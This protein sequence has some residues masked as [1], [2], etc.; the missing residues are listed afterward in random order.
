[1]HLILLYGPWT[2]KHK[3]DHTDL[4][5]NITGSQVQSTWYY[6]IPHTTASSA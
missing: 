2:Y 3:C 5:R 1:M 6:F 4:Q